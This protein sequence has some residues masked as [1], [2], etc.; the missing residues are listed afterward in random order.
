MMK[1]CNKCGCE[2]FVV[3]DGDNTC[4]QCK[5]NPFRK[6]A[7]DRKTKRERE[8]ISM[9]LLKSRGQHGGTYWR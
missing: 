3:V 1:V 7:R 2:L 4:D 9:G 6:D 5:R 8:L